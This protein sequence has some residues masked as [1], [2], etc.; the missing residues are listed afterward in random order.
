MLH[1]PNLSRSAWFKP[2]ALLVSLIALALLW[3]YTALSDV[4]QLNQ[5]LARAEALRAAPASALVVP[6]VFVVL[7][8]LLVPV[9]LLRWTAVIAFGP[10]LGTVYATVGGTFAAL[11]GH[12]VGRR[13]GAESIERMSHGGVHKVR[14]RMQGR[15]VLAVAAVRLLPLGP[16]TIINAVLGALGIP[17]RDFLLGTVLVMIPTLILMALAVSAFPALKHWLFS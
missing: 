9:T 5:L 11:I 3:R 1:V 8:L 14:A 2:V 13:A 12:E 10:I 17:R 15:G 7:A 16:F 4:I 6:V